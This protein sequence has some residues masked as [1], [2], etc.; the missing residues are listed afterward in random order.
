MEAGV[1]AVFLLFFFV[2][3]SSE[4]RGGGGEDPCL[5]FLSLHAKKKLFFPG[6]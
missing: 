2:F 6:A 1:I 5:R 4:E 3:F